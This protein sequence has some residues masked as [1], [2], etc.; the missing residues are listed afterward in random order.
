MILTEDNNNNNNNNKTPKDETI[1]NLSH[2]CTQL[3]SC[4]MSAHNYNPVTCL[5]TITNLS[6]EC[7]QLQSC[8]MSA[9]NYNP[10]TWMHTITILSHVCTQLQSCHMSAHNYKP[11]T[12][13]YTITILSHVCTQYT[14]IICKRM[15][16]TVDDK[17]LIPKQ[18][19]GCCRRYQPPITTHPNLQSVCMSQPLTVL[20]SIWKYLTKAIHHKLPCIISP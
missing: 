11:V 14:S 19:K 13:M 17:V 18:Q 15:Q 4:H 12:W 2:E 20:S 1:T 10:V 8:H 16:Q 9:H 5:H 7:T 3:Q 6:H